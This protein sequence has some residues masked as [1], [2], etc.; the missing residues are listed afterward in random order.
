MKRTKTVSAAYPVVG[1]MCA[2]CAGTVRD[3]AAALE[4]V[5]EAEVNFAS[6]E[7][8]VSYDPSVIT[9]AAIA[10][11]IKGAGYEMIVADDARQAAEEADRNEEA[12]YRRLTRQTILAWM[13]SAPMCVVCVLHLHFPGMPWVM[14]AGALIVMIACGARF[15]SVGLRNLL[16]GRASMETLVALSTAVSFL[17]S[18]VA[19]LA[20][21]W[22]TDRGLSADMY[23]EAS[24]MIIAFVL[25]GKLM[26]HRARRGTGAAIRA[27]MSLTPDDCLAVKSDGA[28][29]TVAVSSLRPGDR[30]RVLPGQHIPVDGRV[31]SELAVIDESMLTGEP[32]SAERCRG[33]GVSAGT[34][35]AGAAPFDVVT[36]KSGADTTLAH[37]IESVRRAQGSKAPVQRLVD[38]VAAIFVPTVMALALVAA[39]VWVLLGGT[40]SIAHAMV[41]AVSVLVIACPCALGLATPTAVMVGIGR[42]ARSGILVKDAAALE[43]LAAVDCM[44]FDKTGTLTLGRPRVAETVVADGADPGRLLAV[45]AGAERMSA[46]PLAAAIVAYAE[47]EGVEDKAVDDYRYIIGRG[48][49]CSFEGRRF[50]IGSPEGMQAEG[51]DIPAQLSRAADEFAATGA[52]V[53]MTAEEGVCLMVMA[54]SD[55]IRPEAR[56]TVEELRRMGVESVLLSGDNAKAVSHTAAEIGIRRS[57]GGASPVGKERYIDGLKGEKKMVAMVGDG[58]NDAAALAS[59]DVSIAMGTGSDIAIDTASLTLADGRPERI[60]TAI[61]LSRATLRIIRENL[62]WAFIYN[63]IGIPIAA[64]ALYPLTGGMLSPAYASAAMAMSSVSVV[65][66]SLRLNRVRL[67]RVKK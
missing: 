34:L 60:P 30:V 42:G 2:V 35:N 32:I 48:I 11:A 44:V 39:A 16:K 15:Y 65:L 10:E 24:A 49:E 61:A 59:A 3:T 46:H 9:P 17:Y 62:F 29:E 45:T 28:V 21:G 25:T 38:K 20:P 6:S 18:L 53:V 19:T 63:V 26:E 1:M 31:E 51:V 36:E 27:L 37:I 23:Y 56:Q 12:I 50:L 8:R 13:V 43:Q 58:I 67:R 22:W 52:S 66:N 7:L 5:T 4:G 14:C 40:D 33:E 64:G 57:E 54:I 47:A 41:A 55:E